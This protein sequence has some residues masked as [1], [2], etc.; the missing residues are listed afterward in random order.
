MFEEDVKGFKFLV[1]AFLMVVIILGACRVG[2]YSSIDKD[3]AKSI[4][5]DYNGEMRGLIER[6]KSTKSDTKKEELY[7]DIQDLLGRLNKLNEVESEYINKDLR[8]ELLD[9]GARLYRTKSDLDNARKK[10]VILDEK[11]QN[12][13]ENF[14]MDKE[15]SDAE[16]IVKTF[17]S[18]PSEI[19]YTI[20]DFEKYKKIEDRYYDYR[21]DEVMKL[22]DEIGEVKYDKDSKDKLYKAGMA[23]RRLETSVQERVKNIKVFNEKL[24]A[25][26][27]LEDKEKGSHKDMFDSLIPG[28]TNWYIDNKYKK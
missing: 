10:V 23:Y 13:N 25:Y 16:Y 22:I 19:R 18:I 6:Y 14:D 1:G 15:L 20:K 27:E 5:E 2:Y 17:Y 26:Y 8:L 28:G 24:D 21:A 3:E 4:A 12:I 11:I 7:Y 9:L